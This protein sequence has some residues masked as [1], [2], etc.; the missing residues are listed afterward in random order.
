[1]N[2]QKTAIAAFALT[3][4]A[5]LAGANTS[6]KSAAEDTRQNQ[7]ASSISSSQQGNGSSLQSSASDSQ[8]R[9]AQQALQQQGHD[10]GAID[11]QL[12]PNTK[13]ALKSFQQSKG[14]QASGQIDQQ[15]LAALNVQGNGGM[16]GMQS[17]SQETSASSSASPSASASPSSSSASAPSSQ[18]SQSGTS[19]ASSGQQSSGTKY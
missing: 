9:L 16:S 11:G 8:V 5:A 3:A 19:S 1:M 18:S 14:L 13:K 6:Q 15:T 4:T 7:A 17:S 12:G 2:L 10:P